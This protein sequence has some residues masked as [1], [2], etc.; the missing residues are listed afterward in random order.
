MTENLIPST[1]T[2]KSKVIHYEVK[3]NC[4]HNLFP[5]LRLESTRTSALPL[6][7]LKRSVIAG[8]SSWRCD[9]T[10]LVTFLGRDVW[11]LLVCL[12][13]QQYNVTSR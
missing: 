7:T 11:L 2:G 4:E 13:I 9:N 3:G 10:N 6:E 12:R 1:S 8:I 5:T